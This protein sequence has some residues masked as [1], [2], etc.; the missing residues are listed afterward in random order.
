MDYAYIS[1]NLFADSQLKMGQLDSDS[2]DENV[3]IIGVIMKKMKYRCSSLYDFADEETID[4]N[5]REK[6]RSD[7]LVSDE[8]VLE[9]ESD[10][11]V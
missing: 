1:S 8:D 10:Q 11:Q 2:G 4:L 9:F 7:N 3:F 6:L 5:F